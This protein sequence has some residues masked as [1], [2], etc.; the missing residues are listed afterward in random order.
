MH[1]G[2]SYLDMELILEEEKTPNFI[3]RLKT[4]QKYTI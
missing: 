1:Q 4:E 3:Q 2:M